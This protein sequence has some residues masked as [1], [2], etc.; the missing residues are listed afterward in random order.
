MPA[1]TGTRK[2]AVA[3]TVAT[4]ATVTAGFATAFSAAHPGLRAPASTS[5]SQSSGRKLLRQQ[6]VYGSSE[7]KDFKAPLAAAAAFGVGI[8]AAKAQASR[9]KASR[10]RRDSNFTARGTKSFIDPNKDFEGVCEH[11]GIT[12]SRYLI[13]L[14]RR[15]IID[16]DLVSIFNS[17]RE[18]T[19]VIAKLVNTAP[20]N[21]A[22]LLGL[23]GE[24]NVQGEDQKKLD[25]ITNEVFKNALR[26]T[27]K[28]GTLA[29]EEE[30]APVQAGG[31]K[32]ANL[33]E[34]FADTGKYVCVFDPLDGSSNV[35]AGI[36]VGTIFG[37]FKEPDAE[38]CLLEEIDGALSKD[39]AQCLAAALQPGKALVAA[40][41][42]LYSSST[43][44]VVTV[45]KGCVGF[46]LDSTIGEFVL[47]RPN[48]SIPKRG[49]IYSCNQA[50]IGQWDA[51]MRDY[52]DAIRNGEGESG[53]AYSLRYI[54][55]MVG[56]IHRTLLYGGIFAY[57]ADKKNE[58]GKLR[59]LYEG[60]P[61]SMILEQAGGMAITGHNRVLDIPPTGVHQRVPVILGSVEDVLECKKYYDNCDDPSLRERCDKRMR[62]GA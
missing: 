9:R 57:P 46:T 11:S 49:K 20:L 35:D 14:G 33:S 18:A 16:D 61:M 60:A 10:G 6:Q 50:N 32:F 30:D 17:V 8:A 29:S 56:D 26:Y 5:Q 4:A 36:P 21:Q 15:G 58:D 12:L 52:I 27:G 53:K 24:V 31:E 2:T 59:L 3:A 45:G 7:A 13:E 51:P 1:M 42:V 25:V 54:G 22:N 34:A 41:Y 48:I 62:A 47:T 43:E 39:Q 44:L 40:G 23:Q 37:V 19:Q 38:E 28:L 55:S